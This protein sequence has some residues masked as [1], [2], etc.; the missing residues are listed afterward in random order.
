[1]FYKIFDKNIGFVVMK[2]C[3]FMSKGRVTYIIEHAKRSL[4]MLDS[5]YSFTN[6]EL[7]ELFDLYWESLSLID[8]GEAAVR[9]LKKISIRLH[10]AFFSKS[11][12][13][14]SKGIYMNRED[15]EN[16]KAVLEQMKKTDILSKDELSKLFTIRAIVANCKQDSKSIFEM[17]KSLLNSVEDV[18]DQEKEKMTL[19][20][21]RAGDKTKEED[22]YN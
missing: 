1:M 10:C 21:F 12:C 3:S 15:Y 7:Q 11:R 13:C 6:D 16:M 22:V 4:E 9:E 17:A 2:F 20:K 14:Y 5:G 18:I 19:Q 8:N